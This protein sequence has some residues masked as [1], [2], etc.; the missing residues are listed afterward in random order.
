MK[1]TI[2]LIRHSEKM[3]PPK[4]ADATFDRF[5]PLSVNGERKA[6]GLLEMSELRNADAAYVSPFAR[7]LSTLRYIMEEDHLQPILDERLKELEFGDMPAHAGGYSPNGHDM[8][9]SHTIKPADD[10]MNLRARQWEDRNLAAPGGESLNECCA[11]IKEAI[12]EIVRENEG[13]KVL[14]GSHGAALCAY[15]STLMPEIGDEY[16]GHLPQ[17]AVFRIEFDGNRVITAERLELP[18]SAC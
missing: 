10:S 1:T 9:P 2:Y 5:Q 14:I 16:T 3:R 8:P 13:K 17:P 15:M 11:R 12:D 7:T 6:K 18:A 4:N